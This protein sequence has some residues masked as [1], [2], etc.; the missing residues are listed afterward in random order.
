MTYVE[1][2]EE[3][4][5]MITLGVME[6]SLIGVVLLITVIL[7]LTFEVIMTSIEKNKK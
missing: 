1:A 7:A 2:I 4:E 3:A 5:T 6:L